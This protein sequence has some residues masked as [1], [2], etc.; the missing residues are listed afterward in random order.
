MPQPNVET[1][2][3][4]AIKPINENVFKHNLKPEHQLL[5]FSDYILYDSSSL[6]NFNQFIHTKDKSVKQVRS[7]NQSYLI[8][9]Q[10]G[11]TKAT[12]P[13]L[14][15][16]TNY[17]CII[18][19]KKLN[20]NGRLYIGAST[21]DNFAEQVFEAMFNCDF[22]NKYVQIKTGNEVPNV[23]QKLHLGMPE[24]A[25]Y[26][27]IL[28]QRIMIV[29]DISTD[30]AKACVEG[31]KYLPVT[32]VL[33]PS[34][35]DVSFSFDIDIC[36]KDDIV[37]EAAKKYAFY[38]HIQNIEHIDTTIKGTII[39]NNISGIVWASRIKS[40]IKHIIIGNIKSVRD[41][42]ALFIS[43]LNRLNPANRIW[44]EPFEFDATISKSDAIAI[45]AAHTVLSPSLSNVQYLRSKFKNKKIEQAHRPL[46]W[47]EPK[48][49]EF[50]RF[51]DFV[52][53][54]E[55]DHRSMNQLFRVWSNNL[56]K[57]VVV[58]ARGRY[59]DF[60]IP[61]NEYYPYAK[62]LYLM[63]MARFIIDLPE[64]YDYHSSILDLAN[65]MGKFILSTNWYVFDKPN[66]ILI[67][68]TD[69]KDERFIP[70]DN[71][72]KQGI[73]K[74][75]TIANGDIN[76]MSNYNKTF[77]SQVESLFSS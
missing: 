65:V 45:D 59:P 52:L 31:K 51:L 36:H 54:F 66:G 26:G 77:L 18:N 9:K 74:A 43:H 1:N 55:R 72:L 25:C 24:V 48:S 49:D 4:K 67:V 61:L 60:V 27:E 3:T 28:I 12:M 14:K 17:I 40:V 42:D 46:P 33:R 57:L 32:E 21:N 69:Y 16:N 20:G 76:N 53:I 58:G 75:M 44:I 5:N 10:K 22:T 68:Q 35:P 38:P 34:T 11:G 7:N 13:Q 29:E 37:Y 56:P 71:V 63:K 39:S 64:N 8:I 41:N 6:R 19:G 2:A 23:V 73:D 62:I 70:G 50:F 30:R 15:A 47:V